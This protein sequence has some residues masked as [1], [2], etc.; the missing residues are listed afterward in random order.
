MGKYITLA[1]VSDIFKE[2]KERIGALKAT[3]NDAAGKNA[4]VELAG[5][6][7]TPMFS[8]SSIFNVLSL[9]CGFDE[10]NYLLD[11]ADSKEW[12]FV[13][14]SNG[15]N[16]DSWILFSPNRNK[17]ISADGT[18]D[19]R[20]SGDAL[21]NKLITYK[22]KALV[23]DGAGLHPAGTVPLYKDTGDVSKGFAWEVQNATSELREYPCTD[24]YADALAQAD[25]IVI[26]D[27]YTGLKQCRYIDVTSKQLSPGYLVVEGQV[28][29][30]NVI[31]SYGYGTGKLKINT[32][33]KS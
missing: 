13:F 10:Y 22:G 9:V 29:N 24:G 1:R 26:G 15:I 18:S 5:C 7:Y 11:I 16:K 31:I 4:A 3:I 17:G 23:L 21:T 32:N 25:R 33:S 19:D 8:N 30:N 2:V 6:A 27:I 28:Q 14:N 20:L 12:W